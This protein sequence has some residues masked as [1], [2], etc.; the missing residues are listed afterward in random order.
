MNKI[1]D[2]LKYDL[3]IFINQNKYLEEEKIQNSNN[4]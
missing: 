4:L 1:I 3:N 2:K